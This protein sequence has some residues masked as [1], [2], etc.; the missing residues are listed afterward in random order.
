MLREDRAAGDDRLVGADRVLSLLAELATYPSG[1]SLDQ[2]VRD[3]GHPKATVHRALTSL[4]RAGFAHKVARGEYI[5]GDEFLRLAYAHHEARPEHV[6]V[7]P[8]LQRLAVRF[9]ETAHFAVLDDL[10]VVYRA[11]VDPPTGAARLT[12]IVGGRNPSHSTAVGSM[13]LSFRLHSEH[14]VEEWIGNRVLEHRTEQ[15]PRTPAE[16]FAMLDEARTR[17]YAIDDQVNE[18]GINCIAFPVFL[19]SPTEPSGAISV[20][21]LAYRT[22]VSALVDAA[23]EIRGILGEVAGGH[24]STP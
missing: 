3:T 10:D 15:S 14:D 2:M 4:V 6:R 22:P 20:S 24:Q 19:F 12:S 1:V 13:L 16:I 17:G 23:D 8:L 21:A 11:K 7:R 18:P 5:L 9:G